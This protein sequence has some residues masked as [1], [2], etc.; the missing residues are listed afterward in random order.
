M[1]LPVVDGVAH[2]SHDRRL[3]DDLVEGLRPVAA[4]ERGHAGILGLADWGSAIS[5][6]MDR[7]PTSENGSQACQPRCGSGQACPRRTEK[8]A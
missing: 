1:D 4:V 5:E 2:R 8:T 6:Q 3:P 7:A